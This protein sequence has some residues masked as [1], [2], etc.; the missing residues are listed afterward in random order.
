MDEDGL[1]TT[2]AFRKVVSCDIVYSPGAR[3]YL[4]DALATIQ[5]ANKPGT[6]VQVNALT[7]DKPQEGRNMSE[8]ETP[9]TGVQSPP[10][11]VVPDAVTQRLDAM[12]ATI[13]RLTATLAKA[14]EPGVIQGMG[15]APITSGQ[16]TTG[17]DHLQAAWDW[18]FGVDK[19]ATPP[20]DLRRTDRLYYL[21]TGDGSWRGVFNQ[22]DALATANTTTLADMAVNA[23][24][25]VIIPLYDRL[26][27]YRWYE[28][29][30]SVQP[31]DGSLQDMAWLQ[32][33]GI[34]N[35]PVI[36]DGAAYTE[37]TVAN[38][39]ES[40]SF[41]KHGGYVGI[42][43]KMLR[44]SD[45]ARIQA[46]PKALTTSAIQTRSYAVSYL[47][48]QATGTGPTLD[49]DGV[50]LF[51]TVTH[52]NLA[53]TAFSPA[54]W[55]AARI[56][57]YKMTEMGSSK[58][59]GF[60]PRF[61]LGP[62]DLYDAALEAFG[63]GQGAGGKPGTGDN[64]VNVYAVDRPGDPRPIPIAVP[65][66]TDTNSWAYLADPVLCPVICM[67]YADSPGGRSHPAP[68][69][70]AVT[71][72]L[73]GLMFTNDTLPIKIRDQWALG[74]ATWRGIGKRNVA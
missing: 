39:K 22:R 30:I 57:C 40:D 3:A 20:P 28:P 9:I 8:Q 42:T 33:G 25:K 23:M 13:E 68:E 37:L 5:P 55:A 73:A 51:H 61:W 53:T 58:R 19:C 7:G 66:F 47:F 26:A 15:H 16:M 50:V 27:H 54:A 12:T 24:N 59:M 11:A 31:T 14:A 29:L 71:S 72:P 44:N 74:V 32:F 17:L 63:Y 6:G 35:L 69:L 52:G 46:I 41:V 18:V 38:S 48:T 70:F 65:E 60:S 64:T 36:A 49:D 45:I 2:T 56:E 62:I 4:R 21:L 10:P 67:A 1:R 34:A 43:D